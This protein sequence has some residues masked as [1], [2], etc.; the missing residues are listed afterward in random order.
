MREPEKEK[1]ETE[2]EQIKNEIQDKYTKRIKKFG[3][4]IIDVV[5][6]VAEKIIK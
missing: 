3:K 4:V 2:E 1:Q 5:S 6:E